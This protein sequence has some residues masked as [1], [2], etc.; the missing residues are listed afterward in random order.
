MF[1]KSVQN[2]N[3]QEPIALRTRSAIRRSNQ[4]KLSNELKHLAPSV[5]SVADFNIAI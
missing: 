1:N 4:P 5:G 3:E 2:V